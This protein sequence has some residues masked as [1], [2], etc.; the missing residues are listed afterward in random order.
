MLTDNVNLI[1]RLSDKSYIYIRKSYQRLSDNCGNT[2]EKIFE[3]VIVYITSDKTII[4]VEIASH[5]LRFSHISF[6]LIILC[7]ISRRASKKIT[8]AVTFD[9]QNCSFH[10]R[11]FLKKN[12]R[13]IICRLSVRLQIFVQIRIFMNMIKKYILYVLIYLY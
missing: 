2:I 8:H 10:F 7:Y 3:I 1:A 12:M 11:M 9:V 13:R 6:R 5:V 4:I